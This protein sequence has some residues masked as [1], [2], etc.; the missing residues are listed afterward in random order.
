MA[1]EAALAAL[2]AACLATFGRE[3]TYTPRAGARPLFGEQRFGGRESY[4]ITGIL[5]PG[6]ELEERFPESSARL[7]VRAADLRAEPA[8]GD[9]VSIDGVAYLVVDARADAAGGVTLDLRQT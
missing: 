6:R 5:E 7:F 9:K 8:G 3:V 4:P 1:W 2:N